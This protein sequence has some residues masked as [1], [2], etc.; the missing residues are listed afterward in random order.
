MNINHVISF[1]RCFY[2]GFADWASCILVTC[3]VVVSHVGLTY[4]FK[5]VGMWLGGAGAV[6][7]AGA[8]AGEVLLVDVG[9][10]L[11]A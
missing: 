6:Q 7:G 2:S 11:M 4:L 3:V 10:N 5:D 8:L 1:C 9:G